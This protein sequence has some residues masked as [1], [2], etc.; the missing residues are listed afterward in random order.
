M[1]KVK[2]VCDSLAQSRRLLLAGP[3]SMLVG[4]RRVSVRAG[5]RQTCKACGGCWRNCIGSVNAIVAY[6]SMAPCARHNPA[7]KRGVFGTKK[8][9]DSENVL[10]GEL[11]AKCFQHLVYNI[12]SHDHEN[13]RFIV[14]QS[15]CFLLASPY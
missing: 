10:S 2:K 14:A 6:S 12:L 11:Y 1:L 9:L 15:R 7:N 3:C 5:R 8:V 13:V 4:W